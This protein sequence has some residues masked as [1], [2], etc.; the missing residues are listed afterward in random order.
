MLVLILD[1]VK[2]GELGY[3]VTHFGF[4]GQGKVVK[5]KEKVAN[6]ILQSLYTITKGIPKCHSVTSNTNKSLIEHKSSNFE[7]ITR[8]FLK[9]QRP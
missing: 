9:K 5:Y 4:K 7:R 2:G 1:Q 8:Q 6:F 3:Q